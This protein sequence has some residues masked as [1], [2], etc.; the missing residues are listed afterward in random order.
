VV[1]A[2]HAGDDV[3]R[4]VGQVDGGG[5]ERVDVGHVE[6]DEARFALAAQ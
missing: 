1:T 3:E 6:D 4:G 5:S 2:V